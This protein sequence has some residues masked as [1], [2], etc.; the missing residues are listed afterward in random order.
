MSSLTSKF[1]CSTRRLLGVPTVWLGLLQYLE[2]EGHKL[3]S[4]DQVLVG[5]SAAPYSMIKAFDEQ[6]DAFLT[7]GWGMTEMSPLGT[8]NTPTKKAK[9]EK[10]KTN[11]GVFKLTAK[12]VP[13]IT[14]IKI[15]IPNDLTI[16]KSTASC[17][18]CVFV[19]MID[20]GTI[21]ANEVP[22]DKCILVTISKSKTV[23]A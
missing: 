14:P 10:N 18:I 20:V 12:N 8:I 23:K 3:D 6:H 11:A 22:T 5:G 15:N 7:H 16:L 2:G 13:A 17:S 21:I 1:K 4:V 19:E 9:I